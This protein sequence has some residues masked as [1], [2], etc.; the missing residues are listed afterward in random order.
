MCYEKPSQVWKDKGITTLEA[1]EPLGNL[2]MPFGLKAP[3]APLFGYNAL[4]VRNLANLAAFNDLPKQT[5]VIT[6]TVSKN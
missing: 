5:T 4:F 6:L 3:A 1:T 2:W